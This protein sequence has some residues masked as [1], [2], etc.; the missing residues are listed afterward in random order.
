[1]TTLKR[2]TQL[3][4]S[5]SHRTLDADN[6]FVGGTVYVTGSVSA[7]VNLSTAGTLQVGQDAFIT[8]SLQVTGSAYFGDVSSDVVISTAQFTGSNGISGSLVQGTTLLGQQIT[9]SYLSGS[10]IQNFGTTAGNLG[11]ALVV[12]SPMFLSGTEVSSAFGATDLQFVVGLK[13]NNY[14]FGV[15][16]GSINWGRGSG[17]KIV[18]SSTPGQ[19]ELWA[20]G[21]NLLGGGGGGN[22]PFTAITGGIDFNST[23]EPGHGLELWSGSIT[24]GQNNGSPFIFGAPIL[25]NGGSG[26]GKFTLNTV[27]RYESGTP[28]NGNFGAASWTHVVTFVS[29]SSSTYST[30]EL[31]PLAVAEIDYITHSF[32]TNTNPAPNM[33]TFDVNIYAAPNDLLIGVTGAA[34]SPVNGGSFSCTVTDGFITSGN[35]NTTPFISFQ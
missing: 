26:V 5:G 20:N 6:A 27:A 35:G 30:G 3:N 14:V 28:P 8:G 18:P 10:A 23:I 33:S 4:L 31:Y 7:S 24:L 21:Q 9:A 17:F 25:W 19:I 12:Q 32:G 2:K 1:M 11:G 16:S 34:N 29:S 15:D 22:T 13:D